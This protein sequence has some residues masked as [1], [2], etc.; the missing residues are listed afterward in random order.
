MPKGKKTYGP[1]RR[2]QFK[3]AKM[4]SR[5]LVPWRYGGLKPPAKREWKFKDRWGHANPSTTT[6]Y[7]AYVNGI[8]QG[9]EPFE[10]IGN[11]VTIRRIQ[12]QFNVTPS[13][14]IQSTD[15]NYAACTY[16][17]FRVMIV[18][19]KQPN[20]V[21]PLPAEILQSPTDGDVHHFALSGYAFRNTTYNMRFKVLYDK[22]FIVG[23]YYRVYVGDAEVPFDGTTGGSRADYMVN[24]SFPCNIQCRWNGADGVDI[25]SIQT[26]SLVLCVFNAPAEWDKD[27]D[28]G[29]SDDTMRDFK[30]CIRMNFTDP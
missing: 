21:L 9:T 3:R 7:L 4:P 22:K 19:D 20:G 24:T 2:K 6:P 12:M 10:R 5:A 8:D 1:R 23:P 18:Q 15:P 13:L 28:R 11:S 17:R 30:Y 14:D 29:Y 25:G 26:N 27:S 16:R